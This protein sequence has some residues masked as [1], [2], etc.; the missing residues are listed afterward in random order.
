MGADLRQGQVLRLEATVAVERERLPILGEAELPRIRNVI[1]LRPCLPL[2]L[3]GNRGEGTSFFHDHLL[4]SGIAPKAATPPAA[5]G[6][7]EIMLNK[8]LKV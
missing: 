6:E 1:L 4:G 2:D 7:G 3:G 8:G 5:A